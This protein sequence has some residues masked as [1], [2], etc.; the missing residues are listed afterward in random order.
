MAN[1][2]SSRSRKLEKPPCRC[3][4][5]FGGICLHFFGNRLNLGP[6][7]RS[8]PLLGMSVQS[9]SG[10]NP[11]GVEMDMLASRGHE[12]TYENTSQNRLPPACADS[13]LR[14][15]TGWS[16]DGTDLHDPA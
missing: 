10:L 1:L 8:V 14:L 12:N 16:G 9:R 2:T 7:C 15:D 11:A 6:Q 13:R 3:R 4:L 5:V